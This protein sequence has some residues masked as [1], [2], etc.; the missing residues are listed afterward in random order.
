MISLIVVNYRSAALA[1]EAI[2]SARASSRRPLEVVVVEN[3][4]DESEAAMLRG[5]ADTVVVPATNTGYGGG[6]NLGRK[7][8]SGD[9]LIA[10][11]PDVVFG[12]DAVNALAGA[13][14]SPGAAVAGPALFWDRDHR[15]MLPPADEHSLRQRLD[16]VLASR[17]SP[18]FRWR[19]RRRFR[20]R[21]TFWSLAA[22]T[23]VPAISGA[24]MAIRTA[25]FDAIGGF[26]ERYALYFEETDFLRRVRRAG[27]QVVYVPS[28]R[29]RHLYNQSA[30]IERHQA[31]QRY[32]QSEKLFL[33]KWYG[34]AGRALAGLERQTQATA[35]LASTGPMEITGADLV[36]EASPLPTFVTAAGHFPG[37]G[38]LEIPKEV[39]ESYRGDTLFLR[40]V[41]RRTARV[42]ASYVLRGLI[43]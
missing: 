2:R 25:D 17:S 12:E 8:C 39:G 19:D 23:R 15:W 6:I 43:E 3:S 7:A 14:A 11:N 42:M 28:A 30:G 1:V 5:V 10:C 21:V 13:L 34:W 4:V 31:G 36:A 33:Q 16:Q 26:D 24:V 29:C 9:I 37:P 38:P 22:S 18:W 35:D 27:K 41:D 20:A 40:I 32:A